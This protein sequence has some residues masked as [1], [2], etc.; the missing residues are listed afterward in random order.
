M[1]GQLIL[2]PLLLSNLA[3][4]VVLSQLAP[5]YMPVISIK[6][7]RFHIAAVLCYKCKKRGHI[8]RD[9]PNAGQAHSD[10]PKICL[11]CGKGKCAAAGM[12]DYHR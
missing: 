3:V 9:C 2:P 7:L 4:Q 6:R 8:A 11:R 5:Q 1:R 10:G 12:E